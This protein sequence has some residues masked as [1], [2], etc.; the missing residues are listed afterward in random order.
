MLLALDIGNTNVVAGLFDGVEL[1]TEM[2]VASARDRTADEWH[3]LWDNLLRVRGWSLGDVTGAC[4]ASVVPGLIAPFEAWLASAGIPA[5]TCRPDQDLGVVIDID[6]PLEAGIDRILNCLAA[7]ER[8][9][10]PA[11]IVD[12]GTA[13]TFDVLSRAGSYVGGAIAPGMGVALDALVGRASQLRRVPLVRPPSAIGRSTVQALQSGAILGYA[14]LVEGLVA[15]LRADLGEPV[16]AIATGGLAPL[17]VPE[18]TIFAHVD[19]DIT[20]HGIRLAWE[21]L[22]GR[23]AIRSP[24]SRASVGRLRQMEEG[25]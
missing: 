21:R 18:T 11:I 24:L 17:I 20:L 10:A 13:T 9:G 22:G 12:M 3:V 19:P 4:V 8:H 15:R 7:R 6:N 23:G 14:G 5:L 16:P 2:R 25:R 1:R